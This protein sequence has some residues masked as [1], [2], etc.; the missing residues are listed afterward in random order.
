MM[1]PVE[2]CWQK[3]ALS[4]PLRWKTLLEHWLSD[5]QSGRA[6]RQH[7]HQLRLPA[8]SV[9]REQPAQAQFSHGTPTL[10]CSLKIERKM[11]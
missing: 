7:L 8:I 6:D 3:P 2:F 1:S 10:H 11:N 4:Q 9:V 5:E